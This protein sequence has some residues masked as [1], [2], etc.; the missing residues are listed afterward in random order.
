MT[1]RKALIL[2][3]SRG[4]CLEGNPQNEPG[5]A[6]PPWSISIFIAESMIVNALRD[7]G[8]LLE[9]VFRIWRH[10]RMIPVEKLCYVPRTSWVLHAFS[11]DNLLRLRIGHD[12]LCVIRDEL[13]KV[14]RRF[15]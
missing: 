12:V 1:C 10:A 13:G 9:R 8:G 2:T 6:A 4:G 5:W 3:S 14:C 11:L 7:E 15:R